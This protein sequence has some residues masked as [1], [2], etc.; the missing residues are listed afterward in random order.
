MKCV[1][2]CATGVGAC[3]T[4]LIT[5][6]LPAEFAGSMQD[7]I[8]FEKVILNTHLVH[9]GMRN[10]GKVFVTVFHTNTYVALRCRLL[11]LIIL[12]FFGSC[13]ACSAGAKH[14]QHVSTGV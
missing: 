2:L 7:G 12:F 1:C 14:T 5:F 9:A 8:R 6:E 3:R 13:E 10:T 4:S 11:S